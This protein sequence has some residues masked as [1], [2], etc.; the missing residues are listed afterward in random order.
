[1]ALARLAEAHADALAIL[2]E[3]GGQA[4]AGAGYG[5]WASSAPGRDVHLDLDAGRVRGTKV[6]CSGLGIVDRALVTAV[7]ADGRQWLVDVDLDAPGVAMDT[8]GWATTALAATATGSVELDCSFGAVVGGPDWYLTRPGFWHG[9]CGPASCWAGAATGLVDVAER[10]VD[11]DPHRWAHLGALRAAAWGL[12]AVLA[13]AGRQ[14]DAAPHDA[15]AAERRAR[16]LRHLVERSATE[17]LDRFG[18]AFGPRPFTTDE[19][20]AQ[21]A[22][23]LHLFLRQDHGERD[24]ERLGRLPSGRG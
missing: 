14:I 23:D 22:L 3:A 20:V 13:E 11:D 12:D 7:D 15:G 4:V 5:V 17:V 19:H 10:L 1:V 24:L 16:A 21:R 9:A 8:E 2:H 6:F 18:T